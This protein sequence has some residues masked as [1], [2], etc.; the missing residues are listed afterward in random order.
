MEIVLIFSRLVGEEERKP[1]RALAS[2]G[3][4]GRRARVRATCL[5]RP[6]KSGSPPCRSAVSFCSFSFWFFGL[7]SPKQ[8]QLRVLIVIVPQGRFPGLYKQTTGHAKT[9][10]KLT[11]GVLPLLA[12][13]LLSPRLQPDHSRAPTTGRAGLQNQ[14]I[15]DP[16]PGEGK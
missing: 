2:P 10:K 15:C 3:Q 7:Q 12:V 13:V 14:H 6:P 8:T 4:V 16:T 9:Y 5:N 1:T 11:A